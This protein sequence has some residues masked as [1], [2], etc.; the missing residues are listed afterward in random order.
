MQKTTTRRTKT[1][2]DTVDNRSICRTLRGLRRLVGESYRL[3]DEAS[4]RLAPPTVDL[5]LATEAERRKRF[6]AELERMLERLGAEPPGEQPET[7]RGKLRRY[8]TRAAHALDGDPPHALM[9]SL[10]RA[11]ERLARHYRDTL[12]HPL[13]H[14]LREGLIRHYLHLARHP[15]AIMRLHRVSA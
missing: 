4:H 15:H 9:D 6:G 13:P 1:P 5:S 14:I 3:Y 12:E 2:L 7:V 11:D 8:W 10:R